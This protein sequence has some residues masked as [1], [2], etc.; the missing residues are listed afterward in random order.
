MVPWFNTSNS[1]YIVIKP[2]GTFVNRP[3]D[4]SHE[5]WHIFLI[6][7]IICLLLASGVVWYYQL[8]IINYLDPNTNRHKDYDP[9]NTDN[10]EGISLVLCLQIL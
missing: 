3:L 8:R 6:I 7:F 5:S 2:E 10:H 4:L 1:S 9:V